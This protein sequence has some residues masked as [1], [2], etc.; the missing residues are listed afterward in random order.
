MRVRVKMYRRD[1]LANQ[2]ELFV[3]TVGILK[4]DQLS[5]FEND[6]KTKHVIT[7]KNDNVVIE[8]HGDTTSFTTLCTN[9]TNECLIHS[10]YGDMV[11]HA[12]TKN[13]T[14]TNDKWI[15]TY[16]LLSGEEVVLYQTITWEL[17][18]QNKK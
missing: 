18:H 16:R 10:E 9:V 6:R 12:E 13:I 5:Y 15:V 2:Q 7:F 8:R 14:K 3:D 4:N 17:S 1:L 11:L